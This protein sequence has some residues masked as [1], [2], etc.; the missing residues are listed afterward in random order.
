MKVKLNSLNDEAPD[1]AQAH[2]WHGTAKLHSRFGSCGDTPPGVK[3]IHNC[4]SLLLLLSS[5]ST[6]AAHLVALLL[7]ALNEGRVLDG[8]ARLA[9]DVVDVLLALLHPRHVVLQRRQVVTCR[10]APHTVTALNTPT[11]SVLSLFGISVT[12]ESIDA[13]TYA[14]SGTQRAS[15]NEDVVHASWQVHTKHANAI[16]LRSKSTHK[17]KPARTLCSPL[18]MQTHST[19]A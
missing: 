17:P 14:Q 5:N 3:G 7:Q 8:L 9:R 11:H 13:T 1:S 16:Q 6:H 18:P 2:I 15:H 10:G 12:E 19:L 4:I